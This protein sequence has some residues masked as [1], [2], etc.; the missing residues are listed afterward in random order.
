MRCDVDK[1]KRERDEMK[2]LKDLQDIR[3]G[4]LESNLQDMGALIDK[5]HRDIDKSAAKQDKVACEN[6]EL[7]AQLN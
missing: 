1:A 3:L 4:S 7:L 2:K 5:L 6:K